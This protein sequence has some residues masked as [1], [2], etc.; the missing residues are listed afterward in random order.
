MPDYSVF[1]Y[2]VIRYVPKVEREEFINLGVILYCR[3]QKFLEVRHQLSEN[4]LKGFCP[5][6]ELPWLESQL[7]AFKNIAEGLK[8]G[9]PIG[10]LERSER[11]RWLTAKRSSVIQVSAVHP[12]ICRDARQ[13]LERLFDQL[14]L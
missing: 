10:Q 8:T 3:D 7:N 13:T 6:V 11:F 14:V 12:G 2:A 5:D 4:R 9:G 1:E